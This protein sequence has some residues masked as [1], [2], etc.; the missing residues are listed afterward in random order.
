MESENVS[1]T[2]GYSYCKP[3]SENLSRTLCIVYKTI[4][5]MSNNFIE[6]GIDVIAEL[7]HQ[8]ASS[9]KWTFFFVAPVLLN[10]AKIIHYMFPAMMESN[11]GEF[12]HKNNFSAVL[13][14]DKADKH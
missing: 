14:H 1:I 5:A 10:L 2:P 6:N 7:I 8:L 4:A 9:I 13:S 11:S 12:M 3:F